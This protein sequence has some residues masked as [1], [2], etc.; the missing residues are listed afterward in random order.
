MEDLIIRSNKSEGISDAELLDV[1][2]KTLNE[3]KGNLK[4]VLL[5]PPDFTRLYSGAGKI[6]AFYYE[7]LGASCHVDIMP[8]TG[9]HE[10]MSE[11]EVKEFFGKDIP[12]EC[13]LA[14]NWREDVV[15]IG[16]VPG[17]FIE[18]VSDGLLNSHIDVEVNRHLLDKSYDLIISIG[19]VVPHEVVGMANYSK[20]IFVG[21]GGSNM[22]NQSHMLGAFYGAERIMGKDFS[23]VRKVFDY[24]EENLTQELPLMY[25]LTVTTNSGSKT[26]IHGLFAGR[27]RRLFE[28]AVKLSQEKNITFIEKPQKK[29]IAFLDE[30]EFKTTWVGNKSVYRSRMAIADGGDLIVLAPGIKKFGED[31]GNDKLIRK[32]GYVGRK[33]VLELIKTNDDLQNN[34]SAAAHLIHGSSDDKFSITYAVKN[35]S[36]EEIESVNYKYMTYEEAC[37]IYHPEKLMDGPNTLDNGEAIYYIS[38]PALGLWASIERFV[39]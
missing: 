3:W 14:H 6:V 37:S 25:V 16:E 12:M 29:I 24:A 1:L 33:K 26:N 11:S 20:N 27:N 32:Y 19:Q 35:I 10:A 22:I 30:R 9:T 13:I 21:C 5:I 18:K 2:K 38:N 4:K 17:E 28:E 7:I 15:K 36:K 31:A 34:L 23:P 8:A 39:Q